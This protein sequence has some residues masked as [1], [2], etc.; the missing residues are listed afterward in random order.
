MAPVDKRDKSKRLI[1]LCNG[2]SQE[3]IENAIASGCRSLGRIFDTTTAGVGACG[4]SCQPTLKK[5]LET[6]AQTGQ[7][8][9][10]P[11]PKNFRRKF[12]K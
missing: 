1:C 10:N 9:E 7:F 8:P 11:K 5:M 12:A 6:Y 4:G 3:R 2:V